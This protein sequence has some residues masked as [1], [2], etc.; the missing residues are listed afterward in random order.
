MCGGAD[1]K[2]F[3]I[4][5]LLTGLVAMGAVSTDLYLPSLP[6]MVD[7][8]GVD[9]SLVQLTL[10]V[11]AI[12]MAL[13]M[14]LHGPLSDRFGRRPVVL[15]GLSLYCVAS[16]ACVLAPDIDLL[17][18]ARFVQALGACGGIVVGR[19]IVRDVHGVQ[20]S[21]RMLSYMTSAMALA[22]ALAPIL[23]GWLHVAFGWWANFLVLVGF[24]AVM[25]V[26]VAVFLRETNTHRD[27]SAISPIA[28]ARNFLTLL[29]NRV[30]LGHA[31]VV[32]FT[33]GGLFSFISGSSFVI[34]DVLGVNTRNFGFVFFFFAMSYTLGA[35]WG[36]RV[37]RRLGTA[38]LITLGLGVGIVADLSGA[39]LAW[40]GVESVWA[41]MPFICGHSLACAFIMPNGM[42]GAIGPFPRMAGAASSLLGFTQMAV[43]SIAGYAVGAFHDGTTRPL[44]TS[45]A[46]CAALAVVSWILL[47][48]IR[49][50]T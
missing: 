28:M 42:A 4:S 17:V 45:I 19:A 22:P 20:G 46:L 38:W 6:A 48:G 21:A 16:V 49:K 2:S 5:V 39:A 47:I 30:Y 50:K 8:F 43:G 27:P 9:V 11:F 29:G 24:G 15:G 34:I 32:A 7:Y 1:P 44:M 37:S 25:L 13:G 33:F 18:A 10:S 14:V 35:I 36:G 26:C 3:G 41:V 12:G 31:L 23:G 40:M